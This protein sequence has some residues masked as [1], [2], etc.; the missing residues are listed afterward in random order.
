VV[1]IH[2]GDVMGPIKIKIKVFRLYIVIILALT[3][4]GWNPSPPLV[5]LNGHN[6][7]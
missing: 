5:C 2:E 3:L 1:V 7:I 4:W 6:A